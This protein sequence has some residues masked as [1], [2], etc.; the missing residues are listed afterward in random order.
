MALELYLEEYHEL[1]VIT[2]EGAIR[3]STADQ[4]QGVVDKLLNGGHTRIVI[5]C[6]NLVS[7]GSQGL[8]IISDLVRV[9]TSTEIEGR[10][11]LC[12]VSPG[13]KELIHLSGLDQFIETV[14]GKGNAIDRVM[15]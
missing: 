10:I 13:I 1:A 8:A 6:H 11:V 2:L 3:A 4:L 7:L 14:S 5:D 9:L 12:N 15:H